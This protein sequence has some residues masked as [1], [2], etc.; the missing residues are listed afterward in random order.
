MT[1]KLVSIIIPTYNR[2]Q[3]V[4]ECIGSLYHITYPNFE[5]LVI[6]NASK[7]NTVINIKKKFPNVKIVELAENTGAS[8]ARNE[9]IKY[10]KGEYLCFVDSDNIVDSNFLTE[11]I[12]LAESDDRIGF[13]GPKMH[14]LKDPKRICYAGADINL[15]T[16]KTKYIGQNEIDKGQYDSIKEVGHIPN[17]WLVKKAVI[18]KIG[19]INTS[20][21]TYYEESDW[22]MR[23]KIAGYKIM[24]CPTSMVYHNVP[25][26][27]NE[28]SLRSFIGFDNQYR[29]FYAARNRIIYM[30]KYTTKPKFILFLIFFNNIFLIE[31]CLIFLFYRRFDLIKSYI[32]G[33]LSG[34]KN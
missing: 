9:G 29:V 15:I 20:Y 22:A 32:K 24:F 6:D 19:L 34:F 17:I 4:L 25:S 18:N 10:S 5:I 27:K 2:G 3:E 23:A 14:Y 1:T 13:V 30:K 28:K 8:K 7:D 31:Y 16:S 21:H 12:F 33:F 11:L 26:P